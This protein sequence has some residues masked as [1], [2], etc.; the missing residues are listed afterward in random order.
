MYYLLI[1]LSLLLW[2]CGDSKKETSS[3]SSNVEGFLPVPTEFSIKKSKRKEFKKGRKDYIKNMHRAHPDDNWKEMDANTRL[4]RINKIKKN[5]N[6]LFENQI[7]TDNYKEFFN[8]NFSGTW[9]ERGSNNLSGRIRTADID[10]NNNIIY[11]AS[12]GGNIWKGY[13]G[14]NINGQDWVSLNDYMQIKGI[15]ML[16]YI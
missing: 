4:D 3:L 6:Q 7:S 2:S 11:C 14:N 10:W 13:L 16:R 1:V 5:R 15:T 8:R 9:Y 12:S